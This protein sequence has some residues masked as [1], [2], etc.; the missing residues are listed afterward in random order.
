[1]GGQETCPRCQTPL[2]AGTDPQACPRCLLE[3]A[4]SEADLASS[5][6]VPPPTPDELSGR[7]PDLEILDLVGQGGMGI[8]YR[9]RQVKLDRIVAL[10]I[11]PATIAESPD[12]ATRFA[13]EA[14]TMARLD[15]PNIV[16]IH[17]FGEAEGLYYLIMEFVDG[18]NLRP[19]IEGG[20]WPPP[21]PSPSF[22]RSAKPCS[23]P[24]SGVSYTATSSRRTCS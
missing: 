8:V 12:F 19:I 15:H 16:R 18:S 3:A 24:M 23:T 5:P 1:M 10:K 11:L 4:L 14:R 20:V 13:R 17:E 9:A 21:K 7:F 6:S 2:P 22:R